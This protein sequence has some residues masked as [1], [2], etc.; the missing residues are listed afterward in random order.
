MSSRLPLRVDIR[1]S[2]NCSNTVRASEVSLDLCVTVL[3][4][5]SICMYGCVHRDMFYELIRDWDDHRMTAG[6]SVR[7]CQSDKIR[8]V[9]GLGR[10]SL[11]NCLH[12]SRLFVLQLIQ[13][14]ENTFVE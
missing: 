8:T 5:L 7:L 12:L 3:M 1:F 9:I 2:L 4:S 13:V 14:L 6:W 11:A 10:D